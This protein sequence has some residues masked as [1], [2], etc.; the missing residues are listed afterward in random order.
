MFMT[1][2]CHPFVM[3][4]LVTQTQRISFFSVSV[5]G[6]FLA[7]QRAQKRDFLFLRALSVL[8][9]YI[10]NIPRRGVGA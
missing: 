9:G 5:R 6:N 3:K 4:A 10:F 2:V 7:R 8:R 1:M